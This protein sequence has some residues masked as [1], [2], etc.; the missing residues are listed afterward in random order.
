M[1]TSASDLGIAKVLEEKKEFD[2]H[3]CVRLRSLK[4]GDILPTISGFYKEKEA[5]RTLAE[6]TQR[7]AGRKPKSI[8]AP[9]S[10]KRREGG[11]TLKLRCEPLH[12]S[13][14]PKS[15]ADSTILLK[16]LTPLPCSILRCFAS[17]LRRLSP[18]SLRSETIS[19]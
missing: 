3:T 17:R 4:E 13:E 5:A 15:R 18:P 9:A 10:K 8:E 14:S 19:S 1:F 12:T 2:L 16:L 11:I 6:K 7:R